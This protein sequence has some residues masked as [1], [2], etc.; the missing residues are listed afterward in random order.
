MRFC[1]CRYLDDSVPAS[2]ASTL[3]HCH[4]KPSVH[5]GTRVRSVLSLFLLVYINAHDC[6][7][8]ESKRLLYMLWAAVSTYIMQLGCRLIAWWLCR[9]P[10]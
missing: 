10:W 3:K 4:S 5:A 2:H 7:G 6:S 1:L 8:Q 9:P